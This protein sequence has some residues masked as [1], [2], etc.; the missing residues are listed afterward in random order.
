MIRK[1]NFKKRCEDEDYIIYTE[2]NKRHRITKKYISTGEW[3]EKE[4]QIYINFLE[5]HRK[6]FESEFLRRST[7]VFRK[8]SSL[9]RR[10]DS[11]QCRS[12]HQKLI[13]KFKGDLDAII[14]SFD[15]EQV[16]HPPAN[17]QDG[18]EL[19]NDQ[20]NKVMIPTGLN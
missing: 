15:K 12:H 8:M 19:H 18:K 1:N 17:D 2:T 10:R 13:I 6:M 5:K 20:K 16:S 14:R 9:L 7:K 4:N 11:E 3:T